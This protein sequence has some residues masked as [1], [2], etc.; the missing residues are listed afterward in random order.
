[1]GVALGGLALQAWVSPPGL[2][3]IC[4]VRVTWHFAHRLTAWV[5][6]SPFSTLPSGLVCGGPRL[7]SI[8]H[9]VRHSW[10][11]SVCSMEG[12]GRDGVR[13]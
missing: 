7:R 2:D 9:K 5:W 10:T 6:G 1:M 12:G 8:A 3:P 11:L 13:A 4:W